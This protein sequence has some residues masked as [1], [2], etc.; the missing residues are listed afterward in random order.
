M[1]CP[2]WS[3]LCAGMAAISQWLEWELTWAE[4]SSTPE[5]SASSG[6]DRT[7]SWSHCLVML[8]LPDTAPLSWGCLNIWWLGSKECFISKLPRW[9][10]NCQLNE[11]LDLKLANHHTYRVWSDKIVTAPLESQYKKG[12]LHIGCKYLDIWTIGGE[13]SKS[14][15]IM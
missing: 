1:F 6:D 9:K 12:V 5:Y 8:V 3:W 13:Q 10:K 15:H 4:R 11:G 2:A 7:L 14:L